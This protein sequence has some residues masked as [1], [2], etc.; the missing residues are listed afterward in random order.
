LN[1]L[2]VKQQLLLLKRAVSRL[3]RITLNICGVMCVR[4]LLDLSKRI[5]MGDEKMEKLYKELVRYGHIEKD[6]EIKVDKDLYRITTF[7][8]N[9]DCYIAVKKNGEVMKITKVIF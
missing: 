9:K 1:A 3:A 2:Y 7:I 4:K 6:F 8:Y 5:N